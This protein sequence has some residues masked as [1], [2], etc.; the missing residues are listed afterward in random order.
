MPTENDSTNT[1][2]I[3]FFVM[4]YKDKTKHRVAVL[5]T[6]NDAEA[7]IV[8]SDNSIA[9]GGRHDQVVAILASAI[10]SNEDLR[11]VVGEA[12]RRVLEY[13]GNG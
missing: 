1:N 2:L 3:L 5:N 12:I 9:I 4:E 6:V 11:F 10:V 13:K 8:I 7:F